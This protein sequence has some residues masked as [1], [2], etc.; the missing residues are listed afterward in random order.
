MR[1]EISSRFVDFSSADFRDDDE[2]NYLLAEIQI[3]KLNKLEISKCERLNK[4]KE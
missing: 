2:S 1:G 4:L 3:H